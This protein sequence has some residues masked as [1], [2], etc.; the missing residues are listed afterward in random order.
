MTREQTRVLGFLK[1]RQG[2][3]CNA[4]D[5]VIATEAMSYCR[6]IREL[7]SMGFAIE[8]RIERDGLEPEPMLFDME[9]THHDE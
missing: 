1:E 6:V 5:L 2:M 7:R 4:R 8:N 3:W 9:K